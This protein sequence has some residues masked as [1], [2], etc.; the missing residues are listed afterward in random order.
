MTKLLLAMQAIEGFSYSY[1]TSP[2]E[3]IVA[4]ALFGE[5]SKPETSNCFTHSVNPSANEIVGVEII[6]NTAISDKH[7]LTF[8]IF[9]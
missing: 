2:F 8:N 9:D 4:F 6:P 5:T 3:E 7:C 1:L